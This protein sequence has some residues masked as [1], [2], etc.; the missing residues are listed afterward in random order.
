MD[1]SNIGKFKQYGR[2]LNGPM[3]KHQHVQLKQWQTNFIDA[4][5]TNMSAIHKSLTKYYVKNRAYLSD[6]FSD[7]I[8]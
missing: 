8:L 1:G 4:V 3:F 6:D 2:C 7:V 5:D